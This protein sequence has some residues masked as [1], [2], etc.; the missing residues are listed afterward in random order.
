MQNTLVK[1][2]IVWGVIGIDLQG[3]IKLKISKPLQE[4]QNHQ[5]AMST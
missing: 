5:E 3:Q 1:I 4:I 2:P